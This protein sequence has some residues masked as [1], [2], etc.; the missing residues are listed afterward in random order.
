MLYSIYK[1]YCDDLPNFLYVG[2]TK[3]FRQ[4][5]AHHKHNCTNEKSKLFHIYLYNTIR[6]NGGWANWRMVC[7][8][9]VEVENSC[10]AKILEEEYRVNLQANLNMVRCHRTEEEYIQQIKEKNK[11][12]KETHKEWYEKYNKE[13]REKHKEWYEKYNK[14][15]VKKNEDKIKEYQK[16]YREKNK[17]KNKE[18]QKKYREKNKVKK[19]NLT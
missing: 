3:A 4:R 11:E 15:Y 8:A 19:E 14:E 16:K 10:Q 6:N 7:I 5:K 17:D 18:Y 1:I 13:Y 9:T 12:Y 2:S